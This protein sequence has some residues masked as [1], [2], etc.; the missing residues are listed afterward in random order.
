MRSPALALTALLACSRP[1]SP[2][3][4]AKQPAPP[5]IFE[6]EARREAATPDLIA[7]TR[8]AGDEALRAIRALGRVGDAPAIAR[9]LELLA[10]PEP[11]RREA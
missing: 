2:E 4:P 5:A 1:A 11:P 8:E 6:L 10:A 9:L 7:R 3:A